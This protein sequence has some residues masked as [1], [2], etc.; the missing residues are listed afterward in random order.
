MEFERAG[1]SETGANRIPVDGGQGGDG[2]SADH[3]VADQK[4]T[5]C[6]WVQRRTS[7][8]RLIYA[9]SPSL[10]PPFELSIR[11]VIREKI[12]RPDIPTYGVVEPEIEIL[13]FAEGH[14]IELYDHGVF[15]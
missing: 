5:R 4:E 12:R 6:P 8:G 11:F 15:R 14:I 3:D 7:Y 2:E 1:K 13:P 9:P 10:I